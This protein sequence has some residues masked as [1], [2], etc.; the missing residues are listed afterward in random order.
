MK[1]NY[2][3]ASFLSLFIS[4][5]LVIIMVVNSMI[6]YQVYLQHPEYSAPFSANL[7]LKSVT[8]G[9]PIIIGLVLSFIFRSKSKINK[10]L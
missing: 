10:S 3:I 4:I 1:N 7:M 9:I 2:K 6:D 5:I 8:Y